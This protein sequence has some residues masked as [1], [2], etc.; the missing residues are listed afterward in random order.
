MPVEEEDFQ[1]QLMVMKQ[2]LLS[3]EQSKSGGKGWSPCMADH[4]TIGF[5]PPPSMAAPHPLCIP[6]GALVRANQKS[7]WASALVLD[8]SWRM[9]T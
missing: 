4:V 6:R 3:V 5:G 1:Q 9:L 8:I 7:K 2:Q